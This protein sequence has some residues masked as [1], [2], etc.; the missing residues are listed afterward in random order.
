MWKE[1]YWRITKSI[2]LSLLMVYLGFS[3]SQLIAEVSGQ[4]FISDKSIL[5]IM[6]GKS[7]IAQIIAKY[8]GDSGAGLQV[9]VREKP[10]QLGHEVL[11]GYYDGRVW[12]VVYRM[13][14]PGEFVKSV[15]TW[16]EPTSRWNVSG[17][18]IV[19]RG[20]AGNNYRLIILA[21]VKGVIKPVINLIGSGGEKKLPEFVD[22]DND[23]YQEIIHTPDWW[24]YY[25]NE[26]LAFRN[27]K[28]EIW[29]WDPIKSRYVLMKKVPW[30]HR[31]D[32]LRKR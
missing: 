24:K 17:F 25:G 14:Y 32:A 11:L 22:L 9:L 15:T 28:A 26:K 3:L 2:F 5:S 18:M 6:S 10:N 16:V 20:G 7:K 31:L 23:G 19:T 30:L 13:Y 4:N 27:L 1:I 21:D 29:K 8:G 12:K